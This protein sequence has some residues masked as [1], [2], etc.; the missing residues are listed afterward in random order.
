MTLNKNIVCGPLHSLSEYM[1]QSR[2]SLFYQLASMCYNKVVST[3]RDEHRLHAA[4]MMS[5]VK[6]RVSRCL[7]GLGHTRGL[8]GENTL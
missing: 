2:Y 6:H 4:N 7:R 1:Q 3:S 5:R 8:G